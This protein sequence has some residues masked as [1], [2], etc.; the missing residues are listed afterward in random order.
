MSIVA[1][2]TPLPI[3]GVKHA[4]AVVTNTAGTLASFISGG[5]PS[6]AVPDAFGVRPDTILSPTGVQLMIESASAASK[7]YY[8]LDGTTPTATNGFE[9]SSAP[10]AIFFP[11]GSQSGLWPTFKLLGSAATVNVQCLFTYQK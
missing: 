1:Y 2:T 3:G 10:S 7:V 11:F 4:R 8:T 6:I 9:L 5:L